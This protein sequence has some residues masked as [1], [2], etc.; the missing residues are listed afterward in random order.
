MTTPG[1]RLQHILADDRPSYEL[2]A[3]HLDSARCKV[4]AR[5]WGCKEA[6]KL[7]KE[8]CIAYLA[9]AL[10]DPARVR[11]RWNALDTSQRAVLSV[12]KRYGG[13]VSGEILAREILSRGLASEPKTGEYAWKRK[14][15][16][17]ELRRE[18]LLASL[19]SSSWSHAYYGLSYPN[20]AAHPG[21]L[22]IA[23]VAAPLGWK[24]SNATD[25]PRVTQM[26]YASEVALDLARVADALPSVEEW[27][28]LSGGALSKADRARLARTAL[29]PKTAPIPVPDLE[30]LCYEVLRGV[31]AVEVRGVMGRLR[32]ER[33]RQFLSQPS[34]VQCRAWVRAWIE[35]SMWQDGIGVVP[36]RDNPQEPVRIEPDKLRASREM[37]TWALTRV[38]HGTGDWL[39][40]DTF[41]RDLWDAAGEHGI[42]FY[43]G[44]YA[45]D[46]DFPVTRGRDSLPIGKERSYAYWVDREGGWVANAVFGTLYQLGLVERGSRS[47]RRPLWSFRL[48]PLGRVVL[49]AP[50]VS[51]ERVRRGGKFLTVQPNQEVVAY[52]DEAGSGEATM[53]ARFAEASSTSAGVAR[54]FRMTRA[55]VYAA[56]ESGLRAE[57][58]VV[59]LEQHSRTGVPAEVMHVLSDS[60][61]KREA[62]VLREGLH[63]VGSRAD[64]PPS[65]PGCRRLGDRWT[66]EPGRGATGLTGSGA[67]CWEADEEGRVRLT[68]DADLVASARL[69]RF[70]ER[71][72]ADWRVTAE[73]IAT[74]RE[75]GITAETIVRWLTAH[76]PG[77]VPPSLVAAVHNWAGPADGLF[78]GEL[79]VIQVRSDRACR[80]IQESL[81]VRP[82]IISHPAPDLFVIRPER[83]AEVE[84]WLARRGFALGEAYRPPAMTEP[85]PSDEPRMETASPARGRAKRQ[86]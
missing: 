27:K 24:A 77:P 51:D 13:R 54:T 67:A 28:G 32:P 85:P 50:E 2:G 6:T 46:V 73:S 60:S 53:L 86:R 72:Q 30:C 47:G 48:S 25:P 43:W 16:V 65:K 22:E 10:K 63:L 11:E 35:M 18:H 78:L 41:L 31:G 45:W 38:A 33:V 56:L 71:D 82:W 52:L 83:C 79:C 81:E 68:G 42:D 14:D 75:R 55:S 44:R 80:A 4:L 57:E 8:P 7:R 62:L 39:D 29:V 21:L 3:R 12:F 15:P 61:R 64:A 23:E 36:D 19:G 58:I 34:A 17:E 40:M 49:G 70:A 74:A 84:R 69:R 26:R 1:G 66:L 5:Q 76:H 20:L 9:G 59:F 37:L